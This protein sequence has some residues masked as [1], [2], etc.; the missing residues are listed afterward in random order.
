MGKS[1]CNKNKK[2]TDPEGTVTFKSKYAKHTLNFDGVPK[3]EF[4]PVSKD[5][6][7]GGEFKTTNTN[8]INAIRNCDDFK[9]TIIKEI[10]SDS[11]E[12]GDG[13]KGDDSG[14]G[15]ETT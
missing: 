7:D 5:P 10:T 4:T 14:K 15:S 3:I 6:N 1:S 12:E 9:R 2:V 11:T 8:Q 13:D